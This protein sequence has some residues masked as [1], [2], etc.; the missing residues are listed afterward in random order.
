VAAPDLAPGE[1]LVLQT[2]LHPMIFSGAVTF[3]ASVL[4]IVALIVYRNELPAP[5]VRQLWLVGVGIALLGFIGPFLR[6]RA[7]E[8]IVTT[9]RLLVRAGLFSVHTL[10]VPLARLQMIDV[11]G[12][13]LAGG[14]LGYGTVR[15]VGPDGPET[16]VRVARPDELC[17]AARRHAPR[18]TRQSK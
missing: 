1:E 4:G 12:R 2:R 5:T 14:M 10:D 3:A 13:Q 9:R 18:S 7:G 8:F 15:I 6:W 17:E 16:F 11:V